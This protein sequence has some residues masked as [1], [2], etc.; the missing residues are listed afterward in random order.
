MSARRHNA[1][2]CV[3]P[4]VVEVNWANQMIWTGDTRAPMV[5]VSGC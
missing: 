5:L 3:N 4:R 1:T 2:P